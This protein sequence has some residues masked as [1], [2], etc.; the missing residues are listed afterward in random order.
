MPARLTLGHFNNF[1]SNMVS[2]GTCAETGVNGGYRLEGLVDPAVRTRERFRKDGSNGL[3]VNIFGVMF[4]KVYGKQRKSL[5]SEEG[6]HSLGQIS[7]EPDLN[8]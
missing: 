1:F 2:S 5:L 6:G 4:S 7:S 8:S 3:K